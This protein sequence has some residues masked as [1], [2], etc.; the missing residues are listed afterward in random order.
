ML[1][2]WGGAFDGTNK[3]KTA[4]YIYYKPLVVKYTVEHW[5]ISGD[6]T[7]YAID[8][9]GNLVRDANGV[10]VSS[11]TGIPVEY[12]SDTVLS[13][14]HIYVMGSVPADAVAG[15]YTTYNPWTIAGYEYALGSISAIN[16]KGPWTDGMLVSGHLRRT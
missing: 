16:G 5:A 9:S 14:S 2:E 10:L 7:L 3:G 11:P 8:A 1:I 4:I 12:T 6:G 15:T 13:D